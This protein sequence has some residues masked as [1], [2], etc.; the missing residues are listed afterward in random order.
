M[1][2]HPDSA[3]CVERFATLLS[4]L[5]VIITFPFSL[6]ECFKVGYY[7]A[8]R[9][10]QLITKLDCNLLFT[11]IGNRKALNFLW[12]F[13]GW[14]KSRMKLI[15]TKLLPY[16]HIWILVTSKTNLHQTIS[17][18]I[19]PRPPLE[20]RCLL[21]GRHCGSQVHEAVYG[22][23]PDKIFKLEKKYSFRFSNVFR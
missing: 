16:W 21:Q 11:S 7:V 20:S 19:I 6:F 4:F 18:I 14:N 23:I 22:F 10:V 2:A 15:A 12:R 13:L 3:S 1:T 8:S 17:N 5:L 9:A